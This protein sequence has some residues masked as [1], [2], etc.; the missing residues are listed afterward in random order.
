MRGKF[1]S[2][3]GGEGGGKST[4]A[5]RLAGYLR[6]KGLD[7]V[8]TREPGGTQQGEDLRDLLVQG[9]PDRWLPLS[10]LLM[11][12]AARVEHVHRLIEPALEAGKW[13]ICDR[14]A[15]STLAYQGIAGGLGL[16]MVTQLQNEA[17]GQAVPD[18]TFLLDVR[19]EAGLKRAETRGGAARFE[20]KGA[21]FHQTLRDGF[22]A[23]ANENPD[24]I[25]VIDAEESF[26]AV[27]RQIEQELARRFKL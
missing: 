22:L 19:A 14:F 6:Q 11:M 2:F 1:I 21:T 8:E 23:I 15:D 7:V 12:T 24:R 26:D 16:D 25:C 18:V 10:E 5:A 17:I 3:E 27:W 20:K 13:V 4:Q 9:D